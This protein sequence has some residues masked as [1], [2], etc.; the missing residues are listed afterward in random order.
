MLRRTL[1]NFKV[2]EITDEVFF[3]WGGVTLS[4]LDTWYIIS[5]DQPVEWE[6]A[7][8]TKDSE[9]N[10]SKQRPTLTRF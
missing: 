7:G 1:V 5:A 3:G 6:F 8:E 4:P 2:S 10:V 9:L